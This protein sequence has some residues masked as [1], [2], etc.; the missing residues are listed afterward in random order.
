MM[1]KVLVTFLC[2]LILVIIPFSVYAHP[3]RTSSDGGHWDYE[4][5]EYHYHHGY[6][7]HDHYDKD[8][9]GDVDC[10]YNFDDQTDITSSDRNS[11]TSRNS[12][13]DYSD[14]EY[15]RTPTATEKE[16]NEVP[17][18]VYWVFTAQAVVI[19]VLLISNS[20]KRDKIQTMESCHRHELA[21]VN[22]ACQ[23][24]L[25]EKN[26][27]DAE[28]ESIRSSIADAQKMN[29][30]LLIEQ[31]DLL[32][33]I[34]LLNREI[35][36]LRRVRCWAKTAPLDISFSKN[37]KPVYW[38]PNNRKPYGD[39]TV[40]VSTKSNLYHTDYYCSGCFAKESHIFDVIGRCRPCKKCA[41]G[42]FDFTEAPDWYTGK[43]TQTEEYP[44]HLMINWRN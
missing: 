22:N 21:S 31:S 6:S 38:K 28:M 18:W 27:S 2:V 39:Y 5:G 23:T 41:E 34:T 30:A 19:I 13:Y 9:D 16:M 3:G 25:A 43:D 11:I 4:N 15:P 42:F 14:L 26:A 24:R 8:G 37:G 12:A 10:P 7:A 32:G 40:F 1:K 33:K 44:D 36:M 17:S 20:F 35:L 29:N